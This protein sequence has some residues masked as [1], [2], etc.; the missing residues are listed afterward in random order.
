MPAE[1]RLEQVEQ[2]A[3]VVILLGRHRGEAGRRLGLAAMAQRL[4]DVGIDARVL[5]LLRDRERQHLPLVEGG[6][7]DH[8][9]APLRC[10]QRTSAARDGRGDGRST[11]AALRAGW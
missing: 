11:M 9:C 6:E 5:L 3:P 2:A 7:G 4:G 8:G 1:A 10:D